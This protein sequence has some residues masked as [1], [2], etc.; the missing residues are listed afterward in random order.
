MNAGGG[1]APSTYARSVQERRVVRA[2]R[3]LPSEKIPE[4][5]GSQDSLILA[6]NWDRRSASH[7]TK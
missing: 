6:A 5:E 1:S 3:H 2:G 7:V 4:A